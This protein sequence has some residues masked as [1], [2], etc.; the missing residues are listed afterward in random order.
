MPMVTDIEE[1]IHLM[2]TV[3]PTVA[4]L[5]GERVYPDHAP[6]AYEGAY[7]VFQLIPGGGRDQSHDSA[8]SLTTAHYQIDCIA[9]RSDLA[10]QLA[11]AVKDALHGFSG[12][13]GSPSPFT[14]GYIGASDGPPDFSETPKM[15]RRI[16]EITLIFP[17]PQS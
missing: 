2:L 1:A 14:I 9:P 10:R 12:G 16:V 4:G 6:D 5:V 15:Y 17:E 8:D 11:N 13:V 7:I 3:D